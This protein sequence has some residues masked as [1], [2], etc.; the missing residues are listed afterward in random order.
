MS[1]RLYLGLS[2][3]VFTAVGVMHAVRLALCVHVHLNHWELPMWISW[4]GAPAALTLGTWA[5]VLSRRRS[6]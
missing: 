6:A 4:L 3:A 2:C 1:G 5:F